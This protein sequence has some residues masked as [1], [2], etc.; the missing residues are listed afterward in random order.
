MPNV[1]TMLI[2]MG[3]VLFLGS[4]KGASQLRTVPET[5]RQGRFPS[6][7]ILSR[8][9]HQLPSFITVLQITTLLRSLLR[10]LFATYADLAA[11]RY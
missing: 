7:S 6:N 3:Y 8:L 11:H 5:W 2:L 10:H 9:D 1:T 4:G